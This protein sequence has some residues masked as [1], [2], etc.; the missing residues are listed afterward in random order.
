MGTRTKYTKIHEVLTKYTCSLSDLFSDIF[1]MF[2]SRPF[3]SIFPVIFADHLSPS[4][5]PS[6][7]ESPCSTISTGTSR[8]ALM[9][10]S[11]MSVDVSGMLLS[12][13]CLHLSTF[14][15]HVSTIVGTCWN[16]GCQWLFDLRSQFESLRV[17]KTFALHRRCQALQVPLGDSGRSQAS[18]TEMTSTPP[19]C[20]N[21]WVSLVTSSLRKKPGSPV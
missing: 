3:L 14:A 10:P 12:F 18:P 19:I 4:Y 11:R 15:K 8:I 6:E 7:L 1:W 21:P 16:N 2:L 5:G 20:S 9:C 17:S 13:F